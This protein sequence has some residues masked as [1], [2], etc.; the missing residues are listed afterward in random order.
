M[1]QMM[2]KHLLEAP[3][4]LR[5][6]SPAIPATLEPVIQKALGKQPEDRYA[7]AEALLA[8]FRAALSSLSPRPAQPFAP[9]VSPAATT[10]QMNGPAPAVQSTIIVSP[11]R[12]LHPAEPATRTKTTAAVCEIELIDG[13]RCGIPPIGRCATCGRAFC[14]THYAYANM[15]APCFA[16]TPA[17]VERA[18]KAKADREQSAALEY[19]HS[20][21]ARTALLTSGVQPVDISWVAEQ[22]NKWGF[23]GDQWVDV[24][25]HGRGWILGE[26]LWTYPAVLKYDSG[27]FIDNLDASRAKKEVKVWLIALLDLYN[28][29]LRNRKWEGLARVHRVSEGYEALGVSIRYDRI[30]SWEELI[31]VAQV[32]KRLVESS[33]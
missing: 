4:P 20:G 31:K 16:E 15:C 17:E 29:D 9:G 27:A 5:T 2:M 26:F 11:E 3:P 28:D 6:V 22:K 13:R 8:D 1:R 12:V 19:F 32:V 14:L 30:A 10:S 21:S 23:F 18:K 7:T 24:V 33:S 25:T